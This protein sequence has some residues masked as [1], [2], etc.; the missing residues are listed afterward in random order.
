MTSTDAAPDTR[1]E[2]ALPPEDADGEKAEFVAF[3]T[4]GMAKGNR[5]DF[6]DHFLPRVLPDARQ[7]QPLARSGR[8]TAG[9]RRLFTAVFAAVPD[10]RGTVH[11]WAPT[12]DG[13]L[14]EFTLA[15]TLGRRRVGIDLID[16]F[17][18]RDGRI[19]SVDT[20][21]D[22]TPL[23]LPVLT[24]PA[25]A[26]RLLPRFFPSG[27]ERAGLR[28]PEQHDDAPRVDALD[29][30]A[31]GRV[32]L[33]IAAL[34]APRRF[35]RIVGVATAPELTYLTRIFGARAV[36]L[37][38]GYLTAAPAERRRWRPLLL[39]VDASD[40]LTGVTH[41]LRRDVPGRAAISM[42]ALTGTYAAVDAMKLT[43]R[44]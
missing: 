22:P 21:F 37:G 10:L 24:H 4:E 34:A 40:T 25:R 15:G 30:L 14:I 3:F 1:T 13:V 2:A 16:R 32:L 9:F 35:A 43:A 31:T 28:D 41:L 42:T 12:D 26:L 19:A 27:S 11:R 44:R 8:G 17:V 23:A 38:L 29:A 36:A 18:L 5:E 39:A 7:R 20:Y 33:G 6:L